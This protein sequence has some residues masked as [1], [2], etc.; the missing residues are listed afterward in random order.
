[1]LLKEKEKDIQILLNGLKLVML[2]NLLLNGMVKLQDI[3][4]LLG[5][6]LE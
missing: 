4:K 6:L 2:I 5:N 1:M 3:A